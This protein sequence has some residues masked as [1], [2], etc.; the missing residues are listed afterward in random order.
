MGSY[1][2]KDRSSPTPQ[3]GLGLPAPHHNMASEYQQSGVPFVYYKSVGGL[4][5]DKIVTLTLPYVSRWIYLTLG[6]TVTN[7]TVGFADI[8][9]TLGIQG[10]NYI[11]AADLN[12]I[13]VPLEMKC[14]KILIKVP[15]ACND[16]TISLLAGLTN[17]RDFPPIEST[18]S[19]SG[20]STAAAVTGVADAIFSTDDYK[21]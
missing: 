7:V 3:G 20:I 5:G 10:D 1:Y 4:S 11:K 6:G 18:A 16:L 13:T 21:S 8:S 14:K 19:I 12:A 15:N 9:G 17:V 2:D